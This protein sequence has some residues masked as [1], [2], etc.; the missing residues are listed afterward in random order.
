MNFHNPNGPT[1]D[2]ALRRKDEIIRVLVALCRDLEPSEAQMKSAQVSYE[3]L[4]QYLASSDHPYLRRVTVYVHGSTALGT[5]VR[6][7]GKVEH[8]V[9]LIA[10]APD[11]PLSRPA[12]EL[13]EL[14]GRVLR[15]NGRYVAM[16]EE[17]KRCWRLNYAHEFHLDITP[18]IPNPGCGNGG[19][20][21][22]DK[23]VRTF[24]PTN[25]RGYKKLFE[26]RAALMP[27]RRLRKAMAADAAAESTVEG[28]PQQRGHKGVL[29]LIVQLL[30]RHRDMWFL[31][32][33]REIAPIS[34]II[35]TLA[36]Q[37]Y[38]YCVTHHTFDTE[39]DILV[40]TIRMMPHFIEY[41]FENSQRQAWVPN[42][43]TEGENFADRW[44][45]DPRRAVAFTQ[46]HAQALA[47]FEG[48]AEAVGMDVLAGRLEKALGDRPVR[49][50]MDARTEEV[51]E[52]RRSNKLF[53]APA[54]GLTTTSSALATPVR[55]N[56]YFGD[57]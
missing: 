52:A 51:T 15:A 19:E 43:T 27:A 56:T 37:A 13:K 26:K 45:S 32:K 41:R 40:D 11:F 36:A 18:S 42:E 6:P 44:N 30:K 1:L 3:A 24:K 31:N 4:G 22:P 25:P 10:H 14:V 53:A 2:R 28:F 5:T 39:L 35:T 7:V 34:I 55:R 46:W 8:D 20:L 57:R 47:D 54:I 17:K 50:V 38:E 49:R 21:V 9:D 48:V 33:D 12:A 16:L 29:R 23:L